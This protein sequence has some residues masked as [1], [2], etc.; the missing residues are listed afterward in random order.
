MNPH[1]I[2]Y[3]ALNM[4]AD[5]KSD[6]HVFIKLDHHDGPTFR[7]LSPNSRSN[8]MMTTNE[9]S[10]G[11][12][13]LTGNGIILGFNNLIMEVELD[14]RTARLRIPMYSMKSHKM[15]TIQLRIAETAVLTGVMY[16]AKLIDGVLTIVDENLLPRHA[17]PIW[18]P[19]DVGVDNRHLWNMFPK[20]I[21][22][23]DSIE[24]MSMGPTMIALRKLGVE[25]PELRLGRLFG[26]PM[27]QPATT[28]AKEGE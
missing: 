16:D 21:E 12:A 18:E 9:V 26:T 28:T 7:H 8:I 3:V 20:E 4:V 25:A 13:T 19:P 5:N 23:D 17:R 11:G 15:K 24:R 1:I 22:D 27:D 14:K 2:F 10:I 6:H